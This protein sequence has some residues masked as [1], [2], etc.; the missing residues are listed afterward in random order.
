MSREAM[1]DP[2]SSKDWLDSSMS[3]PAL[4][5]S[6]SADE[7]VWPANAATASEE[8]GVTSVVCTSATHTTEVAPEGADASTSAD[9]ASEEAKEPATAGLSPEIGVEGD[10]VGNF[11]GGSV[12]ESRL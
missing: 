3:G 2:R 11:A 7:E 5:E 10:L 8:A 4:C 9:A 12:R 1:P 6:S